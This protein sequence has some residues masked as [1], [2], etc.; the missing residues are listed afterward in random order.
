MRRLDDEV[1]GWREDLQARGWFSPL[2]LDELEDH[3]R[4]HAAEERELGP[5][6]G[7]AAAFEAAVREEIDE[8]T[9]LFREF[10]RSETPVWRPVLL[11]C[12][13]LYAL[14]LLLP[15]FGIVSFQ[16]TSSS[17][18]VS[19]SGWE[20]LWLALENGSIVELLPNLAMVMTLGLLGRTRRRMEGWLARAMGAVV[21]SALVFGV[22]NLLA[23]LQVTAD[24]YRFM[25]GHLAAA[26]WAWSLSFALVAAAMWLRA[27]EWAVTGP[28]KSFASLALAK[29]A[30][31][32]MPTLK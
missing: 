31:A 12:W 24:G 30:G 11:T 19:A 8:P 25:Y 20:S 4:S 7:S 1:H 22:V 2:E 29:L 16:P 28:R 9:E 17:F 3:L 21:V 27:S 10:A 5:A 23:P 14:S 6:P 18:G 32:R 26:Y 15:G 13:A